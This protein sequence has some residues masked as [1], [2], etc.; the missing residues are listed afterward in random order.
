MSNSPSD[1]IDNLRKET[2]LF[3]SALEILE[4]RV[5]RISTLGGSSFTEPYFQI[6]DP[7][8]PGEYITV[9]DS[10]ITNTDIENLM[11][12]VTGLRTW[13]DT[14]FH[15]TNFVKVAKK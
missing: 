7:E 13:M 8:N 11:S 9:T 6:E 2:E 10:D 12:S 3:Y 1:N 4:K 15:T 5:S 14:N